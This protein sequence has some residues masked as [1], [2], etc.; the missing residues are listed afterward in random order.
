[1]RHQRGATSALATADYSQPQQQQ[2][3][4]SLRVVLAKH[5]KDG[6]ATTCDISGEPPQL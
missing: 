6:G 2:L 5:F 1:M 3:V 4:D